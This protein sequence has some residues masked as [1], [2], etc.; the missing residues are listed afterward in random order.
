MLKCVRTNVGSSKWRGWAV[1]VR[2]PASHSLLTL[3]QALSGQLMSFCSFFYHS[4]GFLPRPKR[5]FSITYIPARII[6][7]LIKQRQDVRLI[8]ILLYIKLL[9]KCYKYFF[10]GWASSKAV[11][12]PHG[13]HLKMHQGQ[14][15]SDRWVTS[16][17]RTIFEQWWPRETSPVTRPISQA[18]HRILTWVLACWSLQPLWIS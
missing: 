7:S 15:T 4:R 14:A 18:V 10:I 1:S 6:A 9:L 16:A 13:V 12:H 5:I 3:P 11:P 2:G 8:L 17:E